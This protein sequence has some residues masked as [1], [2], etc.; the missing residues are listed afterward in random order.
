MKKIHPGTCRW[1]PYLSAT[2]R[3][4]QV[5]RHIVRLHEPLQKCR[6]HI[7]LL[8]S[9]L[10]R[11][12]NSPFFELTNDR[13]CPCYP[14]R[15]WRGIVS[16]VFTLGTHYLIRGDTLIVPDGSPFPHLN[17]HI[18]LNVTEE[19]TMKFTILIEQ[20]ETGRYVVE[21]FPSLPGCMTAGE[22]A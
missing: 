7:D 17:N 20:D 12:K 15:W 5:H 8:S 22:D 4:N 16:L 6:M 3:K 18:P 21:C 2:C 1:H 10:Q 19:R 9:D 11:C 13:R 14:T